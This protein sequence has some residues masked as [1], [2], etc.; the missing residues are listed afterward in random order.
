[1]LKIVFFLVAGAF[2]IYVAF[3]ALVV[4]LHVIG[5]LLAHLFKFLAWVFRKLELAFA[6]CSLIRAERARFSGYRYVFSARAS[7]GGGQ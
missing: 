4:A 2:V 1:M 6:R 5:Y 3:W 7:D